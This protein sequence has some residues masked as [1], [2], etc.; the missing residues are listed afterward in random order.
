MIN[1]K[2]LTIEKA[3]EL[4][5]QKKITV[6]ELVD[7]YVQIATAKNPDINAYV[8]LFTD[9]DHQ[10]DTAQHMIDTGESTLLTGIPTAIKDNMLYQGH[11]SASGSKMLENYIAAY[12]STI[13]TELKKQGAVIIGRTNMDEFA[14]GSSTET[15]YFGI[16]KN[17]VDTTRVPGGSSGGPAAALA[18][19]GIYTCLYLS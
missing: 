16:T 3:H 14:M 15:S 19:E 12:D 17:P 13:V 9:L 5:I 6:R 11:V 4:L 2:D 1:T 18:M 10:I 8:E 7:A